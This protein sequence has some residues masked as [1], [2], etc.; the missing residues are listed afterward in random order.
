MQKNVQKVLRTL[1]GTGLA[2][3]VNGIACG[4]S[5]QIGDSGALSTAVLFEASKEGAVFKVSLKILV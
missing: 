1:Q 3:V 5:S 4:G 2:Q